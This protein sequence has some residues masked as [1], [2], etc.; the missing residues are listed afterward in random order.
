MG[1]QVEKSQLHKSYPP[2]ELSKTLFS[3]TV[4]PYS[5]KEI[6]KS[7]VIVNNLNRLCRYL[8][9]IVKPE[10]PSSY[11]GATMIVRLFGVQGYIV[12]SQSA[13]SQLKSQLQ[14]SGG[15]LKRLHKL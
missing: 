5:L 14:V 15:G 10:F 3:E 1:R 9:I 8:R 4:E 2:S 6:E 12:P 13:L 11:E 7:N